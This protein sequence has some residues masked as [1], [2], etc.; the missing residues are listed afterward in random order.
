MLKSQ[1]N[2]IFLTWNFV[3][4]IE[5]MKA[6]WWKIVLAIFWIDWKNQIQNHEQNKVQRDSLH[7]RLYY[8]LG[9]IRRMEFRKIFHSGNI[10]GIYNNNFGARGRTWY[11]H[12]KFI[13]TVYSHNILIY[14][15]WRWC[16]RTSTMILDSRAQI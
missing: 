8:F 13:N 12:P 6:T 14:I 11:E 15:N 2:E 4:Q 1:N 5:D 7:G 9:V 3:N 10:F 16:I